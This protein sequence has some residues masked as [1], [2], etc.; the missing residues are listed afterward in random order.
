LLVLATLIFASS[1]PVWIGVGAL[2]PQVPPALVE[3]IDA[4]A[5]SSLGLGQGQSEDLEAWQQR[6]VAID[7]SF[8]Q[9]NLEASRNAVSRLITALT[10]DQHPWLQS[11]DLLADALLML[12]QIQLLLD[13]ELGAAAAFQSHHALRPSALPDASL[14]HPD[15]LL[16]YERLA[17]ATLAGARRSLQVGAR[18]VGATVWLD[19]KPRGQTPMT[20]NGLL[21]GRHYLRIVAGARSIQQVVDLG[22]EGRIVSVDLGAD[23]QTSGAFFAAWRERSG[24]L[25][26]RSALVSSGRGRRRFALALRSTAQG[27]Q[28]FGVRFDAE[29]QVSALSVLELADAKTDLAPAEAL[30]R[31]LRDGDFSEP[32]K[33]LI[34][35]A[36]GR[37]PSVIKP[38][39]VGAVASGL[40]V[41]SASAVL[42]ILWLQ[43][44]SG[45]VIDPGGLR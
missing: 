28:L 5:A 12:G 2:D 42:L 36:F 32:P 38:L 11:V 31:S 43:D 17:V 8:R 26:L 40:M 45:I 3:R 29:G 14:Y 24:L 37:A 18:P 33:R 41:A 44:D 19:G 15:T 30:V 7:S 6:L 4:L 9:G 13:D 27:Y 23:A 25:R 1:G 10:S 35:Q 21:P 20:L 39:V 16:A 34:E 22:N